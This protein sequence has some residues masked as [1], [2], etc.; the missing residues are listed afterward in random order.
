MQTATLCGDPGGSGAMAGALDVTA[1][2][3][4]Q[5]PPLPRSRKQDPLIPPISARTMPADGRGDG[6]RRSPTAPRTPVAGQPASASAAGHLRH[7]PA[8][9]LEGLSPAPGTLCGFGHT[10]PLTAAS[11]RPPLAE[12]YPAA[13]ATPEIE[14]RPGRIEADPGFCLR[15]GGFAVSLP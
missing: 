10:L 8:P 14:S 7:L 2:H 5:R 6:S 3:L 11:S 13:A 4:P 15:A 12:R 1:D 9:T